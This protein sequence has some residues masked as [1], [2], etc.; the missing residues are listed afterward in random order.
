MVRIKCSTLTY[1]LQSKSLP[2]GDHIKYNLLPLLFKALI[3]SNL[4]C[5]NTLQKQTQV[6]F[7]S[8]CCFPAHYLMKASSKII[9]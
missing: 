9:E 5:T 3:N 7:S 1:L 8:V 6:K 2:F 4:Q